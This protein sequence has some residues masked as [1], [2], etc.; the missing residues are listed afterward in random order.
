M[1]GRKIVLQETAIVALGQLIGILA[2]LGI[3]ALLGKF[4]TSVL[5][6]GIA[7]GFLSLLNF[8]LMAMTASLASDKAAAGDPEAGKKL[9]KNSYPI[10]LVV[11]ALLLLVFAKSGYFHVISL[12]IPL[13]FV[14]P[15]LTIAEFF[16]KKEA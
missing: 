12:V 1:E 4:D 16:R 9:V 6:G 15:T 10:R 8:F 2:M 14:R 3:F 13:A 5:L 11:L 7:G